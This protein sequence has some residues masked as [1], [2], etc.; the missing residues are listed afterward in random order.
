MQVELS[1]TEIEI[2]MEWFT[3]YSEDRGTFQHDDDMYET[4]KAWQEQAEELE[5]ID[6]NDCAGGACKL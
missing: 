5:S 4:L 6:L 1:K 3:C 2:L